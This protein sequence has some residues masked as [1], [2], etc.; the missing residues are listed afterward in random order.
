MNP[1]LQPGGSRRP[2]T[3]PADQRTP[4]SHRGWD[5][6]QSLQPTKSRGSLPGMR[7]PWK[8]PL[9]SQAL[10]HPRACA[11][12]FV[13][14]KRQSECEGQAAELPLQLKGEG[15]TFSALLLVVSCL[16]K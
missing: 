6:G 7:V 11:L 10:S 5:P 14:A 3:S 12:L 2:L 4:P 1:S 9:H 15:A 13:C 8:S 16:L